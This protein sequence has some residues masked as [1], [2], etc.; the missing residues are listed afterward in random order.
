MRNAL[1][2]ERSGKCPELRSALLSRSV[3][4]TPELHQVSAAPAWT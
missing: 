3:L 4:S 2:D 1:A